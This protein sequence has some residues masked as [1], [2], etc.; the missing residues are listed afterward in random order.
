MVAIE[1]VRLTDGVH[2]SAACTEMHRGCCSW[3]VIRRL[4]YHIDRIAAASITAPARMS[5][6]KT[7]FLNAAA[8]IPT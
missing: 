4:P 8:L 1:V 5:S 2:T 6:H 3:V 7:V